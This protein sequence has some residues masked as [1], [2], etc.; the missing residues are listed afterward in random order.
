MYGIRIE[1]MRDEMSMIFYDT[2]KRMVSIFFNALN[3]LLG[4]NLPPF[5]TAVAIVEE[6]GRYLVVELPHDRVVFPGGFMAWQEDARSTARREVQEETGLRVCVGDIVNIYSSASDRFTNMSTISCVYAATVVGGSLRTS[7]EGR[8]CWMDEEELR[9][10][11]SRHSTGILD[12]YL[13][14]QVQRN[15]EQ[16]IRVASK[17]LLPLTA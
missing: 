12:D 13:R 8:P 1:S 7:C 11:L 6:Q 9:M 4:G 17:E 5:G 14:Y 16:A 15:K 10:R 2:L 3:I